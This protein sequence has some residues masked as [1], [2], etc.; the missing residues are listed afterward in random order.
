MK[1]LLLLILLPWASLGQEQPDNNRRR[2]PNPFRNSFGREENNNNQ[3]PFRA[4][5]NNNNNDNN[6][7]TNNDD[8]RF[9]FGVT[10]E[11]TGAGADT[12]FR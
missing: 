4:V 11:R 6:V 8:G 12:P 7:N 1:G 10:S 3:D 9:N 2:D 5:Q